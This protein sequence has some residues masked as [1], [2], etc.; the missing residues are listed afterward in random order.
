MATAKPHS[1]TTTTSCSPTRPLNGGEAIHCSVD[2]FLRINQLFYSPLARLLR[3]GGVIAVPAP[4]S[5]APFLHGCR[6]G[7][8]QGLLRRRELKGADPVEDRAEMRLDLGGVVTVGQDVEKGRVRNEVKPMLARRR[9]VSSGKKASET[10]GMYMHALRS[11][12][13]TKRESKSRYF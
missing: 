5:A 8:I 6:Q 10:R 4:S 7:R 2:C 12:Y 13:C 9:R 3:E 11:I 1:S